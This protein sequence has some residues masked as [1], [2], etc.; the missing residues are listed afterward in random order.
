V[1]I[2]IISVKSVQGTR[3]ILRRYAAEFDGQGKNDSH[4]GVVI[5]GEV[6]DIH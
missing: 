4:V 5:D 2:L 6:C 3:S 1:C